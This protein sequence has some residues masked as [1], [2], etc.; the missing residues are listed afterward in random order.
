MSL[1][2]LSHISLPIAIALVALGLS[3]MAA[4]ALA[5][6]PVISLPLPDA[7]IS[8]IFGETA[9]AKTG[10]T[11][12]TGDINGDGYPDLVVGA[13]YADVVPGLVYTTCTS[14]SFNEYVDCV[15]GGVYLYLGRPGIYNTLDLANEPANV[16]FYAK[17]TEW[18][19]EQLGRSVAVGDL[20][21]DGLDDIIM[22]ASHYGASPIGAAIVWVGRPS[23]TT[24]TAISVNIYANDGTGYN[25][26]AVSAWQKDYGG[27]DVAAGDV[28]GDGLDD[29]IFGAYRASVDDTASI[30]PPDFRVYHYSAPGVNRIRNGIVYVELGWSGLTSSSAVYNDYMI[31]LPELTIYG[32]DSYDYLGRSLASGDIDNDGIDDIIVGAD[33]GD[34]GETV[35]DAGEVYVFYGSTAITTATCG[36]TFENWMVKELA[37]LTTTADIT[38]TGIAASDRSG[39]DVS[40]GDLN[41]DDYDDIIIGAPYANGNQGQVYVVYGGP[42]ATLSPTISLSQADLTVSG[43]DTNTWLGTSLFAGDVNADGT[44]DLLMGAIGL[45]PDDADDSGTPDTP[46]KGAAYVLFGGSLSG[47]L[48]L[49][50]DSPDITILGAS[51]DDWLGRGLGVGDLNRDGF[52]ELLVAAAGLDH[53]TSLT[54]TGAVYIINLAY[55]QQITVTGSLTQVAAGNNVSFYATGKSQFGTHDV[56]TQTTFTIS[57]GAGG[58]WNGNRYTASQ[59]GVWTVT[60]TLSSLSDT[61]SL[62][63]VPP[64]SFNVYLPII[65][66]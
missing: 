4:A 64:D 37:Y 51:A 65:L 46:E 3:L 10:H 9:N 45:D 49:S 20:N 15:S 7:A 55:P 61:T 18:S 16:T 13:P 1:K 6:G 42:R 53:G 63:V 43:A 5:D 34:P 22:G 8:T 19:G 28:N 17:P 24:T 2:R 41:G 21:G 33:G 31:C 52:N 23:I 27:W 56:T 30:Y 66:R 25:L 54:D 62:T 60:G 57:P 50:S 36:P 58:T 44:D 32:E 35:A 14:Q 12:A 40:T 29:V 38:L 11:I 39:F 59:P 47:S 48:D 26:K